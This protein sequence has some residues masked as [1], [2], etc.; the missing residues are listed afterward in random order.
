MLRSHATRTCVDEVFSS[1]SRD[2]SAGEKSHHFEVMMVVSALHVR[3]W[4]RP[5]ACLVAFVGAPPT[6]I[7]Q[8]KSQGG[9]VSH[10]PPSRLYLTAWN[11]LL[12]ASCFFD[13]FVVPGSGGGIWG[14]CGVGGGGLRFIIF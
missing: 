11:I 14:G 7:R 6:C 8:L 1:L 9:V 4:L 5:R 13:C 3:G 12:E 2:Q 10:D